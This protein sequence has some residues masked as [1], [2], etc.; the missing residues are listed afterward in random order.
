MHGMTHYMGLLMANSPV[1]LLIFMALPVILAETVAITELV[2][3]Y[4]REA[5]T[6]WHKLNFWCA[7]A[8]GVVFIPI[9]LYLLIR[10]II[11]LTGQGQWQGWIDV[12]AVVLYMLSGLIMTALALTRL[13]RREHIESRGA[14]IGLLS[15]FLVLSHLAMILGMTD[16]ALGMSSPALVQTEE[17]ELMPGSAGSDAAQGPERAMSP[18]GDAGHGQTHQHLHQH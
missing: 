2:I 5:D 18:A 12:S 10:V 3:L 17:A 7:V 14:Q 11:P 6:A 15:A 9:N 4:R 16:P 13:L 8:A 1:N